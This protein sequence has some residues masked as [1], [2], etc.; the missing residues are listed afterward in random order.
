MQA[1]EKTDPF[2]SPAMIE[3]SLMAIDMLFTKTDDYDEDSL[4][5]DPKNSENTT[6]CDCKQYAWRLLRL[7]GQ[8]SLSLVAFAL[9]AFTFSVFLTTNSSEDLLNHLEYF[10]V[11][12]SMQLSMKVV[13]F[14]LIIPCLIFKWPRLTF[15]FNVWSFVLIIT[16][17]GNVVYHVLYC[18]AL[19]S[20][21]N[22]NVIIVSWTDNIVSIFLAGFQTLFILG[23][24]LHSDQVTA[25]CT[26]SSCI[27]YCKNKESFVYYACFILGV[28]NF[29]LWVSDSIGEE[30]LPVFSI[31]IYKAY[32][33]VVWSII[34]KIILPLTIFFRFHTGLDFFEFYWK[35][36]NKKIEIKKKKLAASDCNTDL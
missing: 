21:S 7:T 11:Y 1:I 29:G 3:F 30:R 25:C 23:T 31:E 17:F 16:C 15:H 4:Q 34:N 22:E 10:E 26:R 19:R 6:C 14:F 5:I 13:M 35:H 33:E 2:L 28:L 18:F 36:K 27:E 8:I 20:N 9:F 32:D 24:H 12:V